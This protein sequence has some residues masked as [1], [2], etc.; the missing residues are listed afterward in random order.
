MSKYISSFNSALLCKWNINTLIF[1]VHFLAYLYIMWYN[2]KQRKIINL[3]DYLDNIS[4][5]LVRKW[6]REKAFIFWN[7]TQF[8][9][10]RFHK[11]RLSLTFL[12]FNSIIL[13]RKNIIQT[14][15]YSHWVSKCPCQSRTQDI[16]FK[17]ADALYIEIPES[18]IGGPI[19]LR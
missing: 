12:I 16:L 11:N 13:I 6:G 15:F 8:D 4:F 3:T 19:S 18:T 2:Q 17:I 5:F 9:S 14:E 1:T 7:N 10:K